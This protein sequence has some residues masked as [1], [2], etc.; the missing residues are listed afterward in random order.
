MARFILSDYA[1]ICAYKQLDKIPF[2]VAH[3]VANSLPNVPNISITAHD[4][5][6]FLGPSPAY[7]SLRFGTTSGYLE[8]GNFVRGPCKRHQ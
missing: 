1:Q 8:S 6:R 3:S 7:V 2:A 5:V 4:T